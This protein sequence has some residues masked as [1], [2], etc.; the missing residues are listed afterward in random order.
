[1]HSWRSLTH[2]A[3]RDERQSIKADVSLIYCIQSYMKKL[4]LISTLSPMFILTSCVTQTGQ[5]GEPIAT[6]YQKQLSK[7]EIGKTTL[8]DLKTFFGPDHVSLK[9]KGA[10]YEIWEVAKPGD[11][12]VGSFILWGEIAHDKDQSLFF[13]F[14]HGVLA[15]YTSK[16]TN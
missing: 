8:S 15:S 9:E 14:E 4:L 5:I 3:D 11:L 13:R 7:I 2:D 1:M 6:H 12:D 10:G 16:V